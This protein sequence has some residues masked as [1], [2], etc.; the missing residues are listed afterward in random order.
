MSSVQCDSCGCAMKLLAGSGPGFL[1]L[2]RSEFTGNVGPA[3]R[4][5]ACGRI[6]C[7]SCYPGR[8]KNTCPC[9]RDR[10]AVEVVGGA[11]YT[12]PIRL[13]KVAYL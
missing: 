9:G 1:H 7:A 13:V 8:P 12:G 11:T 2:D 6:W 10:T 3:E 4:C 5:K